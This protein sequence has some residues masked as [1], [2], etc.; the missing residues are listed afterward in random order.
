[1]LFYT[2][3]RCKMCPQQTELLKKEGVKQRYFVLTRDLVP[4]NFSGYHFK[5][6]DFVCPLP[7]NYH[8]VVADKLKELK[9]VHQLVKE[10]IN[11]KAEEREPPFENILIG[12]HDKNLE[13]QKELLKR[14]KILNLGIDNR[15]ICNIQAGDIENFGN[16]Y[17]NKD[18]RE[19]YNLRFNEALMNIFEPKVVFCCEPATYWQTLLI[20]ELCVEYF[21]WLNKNIPSHLEF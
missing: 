19:W 21:N 16:V 7:K 4:I 18:Y 2:I 8:L 12:Y 10:K 6:C 13:E 9:E 5:D 20:R 17:L 3:R 15:G 14:F 11:R 1:M